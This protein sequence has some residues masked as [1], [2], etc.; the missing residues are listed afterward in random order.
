MKN[1]I[2]DDHSFADPNKALVKHLDWDATVDFDKKIISGT[3]SLTIEVFPRAE[4]LILDTKNLKISK[5]TLNNGEE[6]VFHKSQEDKI[7]GAPLIID[8]KPSTTKVNIEYSTSPG[9]EALQWLDP[10]Q[11][12]GGE[13]PFLFTQS[14]AILARSWIPLHD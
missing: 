4:N 8:I 11:T 13:K 14:Q 9:A 12:A 7:L 5:V 2:K 6:A 10:V 1:Y 3:A